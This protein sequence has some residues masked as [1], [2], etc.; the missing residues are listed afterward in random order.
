MNL[1][2]LEIEREEEKHST[3][4]AKETHK[5]QENQQVEHSQPLPKPIQAVATAGLK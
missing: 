5:A 3:Q 1:S 4:E 2:A